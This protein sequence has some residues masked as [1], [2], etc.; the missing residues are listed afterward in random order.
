MK[1]AIDEKGF[2]IEAGMHQGDSWELMKTLPDACVDLIITDPPYDSMEKHRSRGTTTRLKES[3]SSSNVWFETVPTNYFP[4]F[5]TECYRVLKK[6]R[7][8]FLMCDP[9]TQFV[10]HPLFLEA[11]FDLKT[12][13]IWAK[14]TKNKT[15]VKC[16]CGEEII[17][18]SCG[19]AHKDNHLAMGM[20][21][22]FRRSYEVIMFGRKGRRS[23]PDD[24]S[25]RDVFEVPW[26]KMGR[27]WSGRDVFP[28]EKP[29][30]L[31]LKLIK[32]SSFEGDLVLD[33][34]A[35]SGS[36]LEA[37][38]R[39]NRRFLGFELKQE[40]VDNYTEDLNERYKI[41]EG[42]IPEE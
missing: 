17:C 38:R 1:L 19:V 29:I 26:L 4:P 30:G 11:G 10:L 25:M 28:T 15:T 22:P 16:S 39:L 32:Q 23:P 24:R 42:Y 27:G 40:A 31:S 18:K 36:V 34:F 14:Q 12:P 13:L 35:G 33:P 3:K 9:D 41:E 2:Q 7:Y 5:L 21:Y 8:I 37:A 20:G 6:K